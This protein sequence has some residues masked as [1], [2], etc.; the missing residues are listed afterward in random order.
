MRKILAV[1]LIV[2]G[3]AVF[4]YPHLSDI[5]RDYRVEQNLEEF[6]EARQTEG[7][8]EVKLPPHS[9]EGEESSSE[10]EEKTDSQ[11]STPIAVL[12]IDK[13]DLELPVFQ[14]ATD[15]HLNYGAGLLEDKA[16]IGEEGTAAITAH[17]AHSH[18][19]LFNRLD[20]LEEGD[21]I[22]VETK[23][24]HYSYKV[25]STGIFEAGD[26]SYLSCEGEEK[27]LVLITCHPL[28][29]PNPP[30]RLVVQTRV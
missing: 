8:H 29:Q 14:G 27:R 21:R 24:E 15:Y 17:R 10:K 13:I 23:E 2:A 20:E 11:G 28:Y 22:V 6:S 30:Y 19:R 16:G 12:K 5:Y 9:R 7:E 1:L 18:G 4:F 25:F 26:T 3:M